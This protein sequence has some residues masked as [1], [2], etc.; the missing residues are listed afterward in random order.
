MS[1]DFLEALVDRGVEILLSTPATDPCGD[2]LDI[3]G[4]AF[5]VKPGLNATIF[6]GPFAEFT[7]LALRHRLHLL[8]MGICCHDKQDTRSQEPTHDG[9]LPLI[10]GLARHFIAGAP[11]VPGIAP[12]NVSRENDLFYVNRLKVIFGHL[13]VGM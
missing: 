6:N 12:H 7:H 5:E 10:R 11:R 8:C 4:L 2:V 3:D 1:G 9:C 13:F